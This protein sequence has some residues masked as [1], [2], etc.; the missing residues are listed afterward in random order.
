MTAAPV[1]DSRPPL[2][3][4]F[5]LFGLVGVLFIVVG[6]LEIY[7]QVFPMSLGNAE[8]EFGTFSSVMDTMPLLLMG[9][10]FLGVYA[11]VGGHVI[12]ARI[13]GIAMFGMALA[14]LAFAFLYFTNVPP[15]LRVNPGTPVQTGIK[16]AVAK[17]TLQTMI[18]PIVLLWLGA[19]VMR[20]TGFDPNRGRR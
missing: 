7:Q 9:M 16:K 20:K 2:I 10:G 19:Y 17:A 6:G 3:Q 5:A 15:A 14:L 1:A 8:W 4:P 18:F 11:V 12:L 13:L